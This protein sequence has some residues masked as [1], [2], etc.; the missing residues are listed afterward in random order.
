M[1]VMDNGPEF[2]SKA[3]DQWAW[4]RG[5]ALHW[6]DPGKPI[7]NACVES[8]NGRCR[9]ECLNQHHFLSIED[10]RNLIEGWRDDYNTLRPH[11]ALGGLAPQ[12]FLDVVTSG[13]P[14][15][16]TSKPVDCQLQLNFTNHPEPLGRT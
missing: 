1:L 16:T 10:A 8:F 13:S 9:D 4:A 6:I 14:S 7:Q 12:Q 5:I 11:T 3:L 15:A 2:T